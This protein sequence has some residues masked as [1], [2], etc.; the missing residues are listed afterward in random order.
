MEDHCCPCQ[1]AGM[2][3]AQFIQGYTGVTGS[4][5]PHP[6]PQGSLPGR[7]G[8]MSPALTLLLCPST[9]ICTNLH[10]HAR[11]TGLPFIIPWSYHTLIRDFLHF[12]DFDGAKRQLVTKEKQSGCLKELSSFHRRRGMKSKHLRALACFH[13]K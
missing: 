9:Q 5:F 7:P 6:P 3:H 13:G 4:H 1:R 2:N 10:R 8:C 11:H 12:Q